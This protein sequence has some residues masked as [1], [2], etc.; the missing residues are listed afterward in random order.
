VQKAR[1][2]LRTLEELSLEDEGHLLRVLIDHIPDHIYIKDRRSRF[3]LANQK[4]AQV[5]H[6]KSPEEILGKSDHDYYPEKLAD[7]YFRDEQE[8]M[9]SGK[10]MINQEELSMD[11]RG[12][13]IFLAS[14]KIPLKNK[15]GDI[16]GIVGIGRDITH[17][18]R[19]ET[20][21]VE[22]SE[23]LENVNKLLEEK[24]EEI[25]HQSEEL[26]SQAENLM[27]ANQDL[28]KL[29][30]AVSETDNVVIIMDAEGNLEW[31]N[32]SFTRI[33]GL[34]LEEWIRERGKNILKGSFNP[35]ISD[36]LEKCRKTKKPVRYQSQA[37]NKDGKE[38]WTQSTLTPVLDNDGSITRFV[39]IDTDITALKIAQELINYQREELEKQTEELEKANITKDKFFSIIAHDL[40]NPFHA[41]LGFSDVLSSN[42]N[43]IP[44]EKK[45]EYLG[46]IHDSAE[47]ARALLENL[48][49][50]SRSQSGSIQYNPAPLDLSDVVAEI[51]HAL[52]ASME[53][54]H[55][56]FENRVPEGSVVLADVNMIQTIF[57][58]LISNAIKFTPEGGSISVS[59]EKAGGFLSVSVSDTGIGIPEA[60]RAKLFSFGE[61]HSTAGT[62]GEQGTGLGLV[63]SRDFIIK[64]G[65]ELSLNSAEGRGSTFTF[66]LPLE[67]N[68]K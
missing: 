55:L 54:K 7:K 3:I 67:D 63:I 36:I 14:T 25:T 53:K 23:N 6:L 51:H 16:I 65:G 9:K 18:I 11:E 17:H 35:N 26:L 47:F 10:P 43:S 56:S 59:A 20:R 27:H 39:T 2:T 57:R 44:D 60:A 22:R 66:T 4:L 50:W 21:L 40:K 64:H 48:L 34:S 61:F 49:N 1:E 68:S 38:I 13:D 62:G 8:I 42:F 58:N 15:D 46:M 19:A 24:Q 41:I 29:T 12:N 52:R 33:Y 30:I 5:H 45:Q 31:V 37:N 28:E 32:K